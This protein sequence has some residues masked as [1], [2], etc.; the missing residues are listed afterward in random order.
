LK[1]F[2]VLQNFVQNCCIELLK[3][4]KNSRVISVFVLKGVNQVV[5]TE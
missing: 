5:G 3:K 1:D 4:T 2:H